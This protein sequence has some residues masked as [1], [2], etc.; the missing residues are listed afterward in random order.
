MTV[1]E[2]TAKIREFRDQRD[3]SQFH[4]PKDMAEAISI[5]ASELLEHFLWR[6]AEESQQ[7][8]ITRKEAVSDEIADIPILGIK[9]N[10]K[11][12]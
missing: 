7:V 10:Q 2:I 4:S 11:R 8:A 3:W 5:E 1:E 12:R 6:S 9:R